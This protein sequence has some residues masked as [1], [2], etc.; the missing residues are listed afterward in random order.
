MTGVRDGDR[1]RPLGMEGSRKLSD[2]LIDAKV[3]RDERHVVPV[4]RLGG[5]VVWLAG[6]RMAEE[7]KV[8]PDTTSAVRLTWRRPESVP[9]REPGPDNGE[10]STEH[11][12]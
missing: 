11:A 1:M 9:T 5:T 6:V 7:C 3:P 2:L 8:T 10:D 4:V 12:R